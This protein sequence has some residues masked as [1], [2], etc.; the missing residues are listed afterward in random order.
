MNASVVI[1]THGHISQ[2]IELADVIVCS[3]LTRPARQLG[4]ADVEKHNRLRLEL[5]R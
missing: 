3:T 1:E 2:S 5:I 4:N